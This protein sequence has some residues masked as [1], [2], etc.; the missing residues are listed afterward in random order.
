MDMLPLR[1]LRTPA[2]EEDEQID[3][4]VCEQVQKLIEM[5]PSNRKYE[6]DDAAAKAAGTALSE[7]ELRCIPCTAP[8]HLPSFTGCWK[9]CSSVD[10]RGSQRD[11]ATWLSRVCI[12]NHNI[13]RDGEGSRVLL[14]IRN[15]G[16]YLEGGQLHLDSRDVLHRFGKSGSHTRFCRDEQDCYA[17]RA[18]LSPI[19]ELAAEE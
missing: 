18:F 15:Q 10:A 19:H 2:H 9:V 3:L 6:G 12:S 16:V 13:V 4:F 11:V 5:A 14:R 1:P 8:S 7:S 17:H